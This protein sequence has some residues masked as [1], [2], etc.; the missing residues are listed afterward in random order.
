MLPLDSPVVRSD[1]PVYLAALGPRMLALAGQ[2]SDGVILNPMSPAQAGEAAAIV[3]TAA[4]DAGRDPAS[5]L[6]TCVVHVLP[7]R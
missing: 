6:V 7:G 1:L 4:A 2:I 5:V 3:R